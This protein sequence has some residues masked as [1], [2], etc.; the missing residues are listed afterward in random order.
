MPPKSDFSQAIGMSAAQSG[1]T[2][3]GGILSTGIGA[4]INNAFWKKQYAQQRADA[5]AD[6]EHLEARQDEL[7]KQQQAPAQVDRLKEA[8]LNPAL[9]YGGN[10]S[11]PAPVVNNTV[12]NPS[13]SSSFSSLP[14]DMLGFVKQAQDNAL[15][16]REVAVAERNQDVNESIA[17]FQKALSYAQT[18]EHFANAGFI[19]EKTAAQHLDNIFNA[20]SF[21][22]RL[23]TVKANLEQVSQTVTNLG[24]QGT[25]LQA[26]IDSYPLQVEKIQ[27]EIQSIRENTKLTRSEQENMIKQT[28][29]SET[30]A[31]LNKSQKAY[32]DTK[33]EIESALGK[34]EISRAAYNDKMKKADK[35]FEYITGAINSVVDVGA[36][37][38]GAGLVK[39]YLS[40]RGSKGSGVNYSISSTYGTTS[41]HR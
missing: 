29:E 3:L 26:E 2:L 24:L 18:V 33:K 22:D 32:I 19:S 5:L 4:A 17:E 31:M 39:G 1:M 9:A 40:S 35:A 15:R 21:E 11:T 37:V 27:A 38:G 14:V 6:R 28:V 36:V 13:P 16:E 23:S 8:G 25:L 34:H 7:I 10:S 41:S 30:R 12:P 20:V